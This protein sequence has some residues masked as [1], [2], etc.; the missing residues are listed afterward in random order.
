MLTGNDLVS[1]TKVIDFYEVKAV[2]SN[3]L[4]L[5]KTPTGAI[6]T[7]YKVNVDGTNGQEYTLGTPGT[8]ATEYSVA[9]KDLTFHT[10]V[11]NGTQFRVYY[12]VTTASDTK[13][14]K[15]SSDAFGGTFRGVLKC[16]VVDEFTKDAFEADL[17]IPN[18]K[19]EDNFNLSL[20][21]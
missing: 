11:T 18:A 1:G 9:G 6:V 7:V 3:K 4:T 5:S 20:K 19:F 10:G 8:N 21:I 13:T 14:I 15:V 2:T 16:L 12:K 17:V